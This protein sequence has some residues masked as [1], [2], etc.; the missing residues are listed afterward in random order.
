ML[1]ERDQAL[2][3]YINDD[4]SKEHEL[5]W[6]DYLAQDMEIS[7]T[8]MKLYLLPG[9]HWVYCRHCGYFKWGPAEHGED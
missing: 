7:E 9:R 1:D 3:H 8:T 5:K 6:C 4:P 2:R